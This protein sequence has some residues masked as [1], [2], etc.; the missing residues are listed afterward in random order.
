MVYV[1]SDF[2]TGEE[3]ALKK[4]ICHDRDTLDIAVKEASVMVP[5]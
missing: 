4:M 2:N 3:F 1:A 5:L